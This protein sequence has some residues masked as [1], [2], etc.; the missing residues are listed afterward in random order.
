MWSSIFLFGNRSI[1]K[2]L[3]RWKI[4][5]L[6]VRYV[7]RRYTK[8]LIV[9]LTRKR[10]IM[11]TLKDSRLFFLHASRRMDRKYRRKQL[12]RKSRAYVNKWKKWYVETMNIIIDKSTVIHHRKLFNFIRILF[13]CFFVHYIEYFY[14]YFTVHIILIRNVMLIE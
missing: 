5:L 9:R 12:Q 8:S 4:F 6:H 14:A 2:L 10:W 11:R 3:N 13:Y 7:K 1:K